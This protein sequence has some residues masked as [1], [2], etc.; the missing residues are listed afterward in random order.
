M[1]P[2]FQQ[3]ATLERLYPNDSNSNFFAVVE[4]NFEE[5][6]CPG[7]SKGNLNSAWSVGSGE[8]NTEVS[9]DHTLGEIGKSFES[10]RV[11]SKLKTFTK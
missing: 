5:G 7:W 8:E 6:L 11:S 4:C 9:Y 3:Y 1:F 10:T 2:Y